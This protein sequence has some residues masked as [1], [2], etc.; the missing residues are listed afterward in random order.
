MIKRYPIGLEENRTV[1]ASIT[2]TVE[3]TWRL[4]IPPG[5]ARR[6]RLAQLDDYSSLSR[7]LFPWKAGTKLS[8]QARVS[9]TC[10]AGTWGFGFWND[11]FAMGFLTGLKG[12]RLP[13]FPDAAWFFFASPQ[14]FL[15]FRDDLAGNGLTAGMFRSPGRP[16]IK[17]F[18]G[19]LLM[20][21]L[22]LPAVSRR[23]RKSVS[24]ILI[25]DSQPIAADPTRWHRYELLWEQESSSFFVD[26]LQVLR[27][28]ASPRGPMGFLL[29]IDNQS[30]AWTPGGEIGYRLLPGEERAWMEVKDLQVY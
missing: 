18:F 6:Y 23:L 26:G 7:N 28:T 29:W 11:P 10:H 27:T 24:Q 3:G 30:A 15:S 20:P 13:V 2:Q 19:L 1:G 22:F 8:L 17:T 4:E 14:S 25:Q 5:P 21:F 16:G 12:L 9:H